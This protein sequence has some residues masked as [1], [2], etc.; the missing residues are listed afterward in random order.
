MKTG[1]TDGG[2]NYIDLPLSK[3]IS[4]YIDYSI[5]RGIF[6]LIPTIIL[7]LDNKIECQQKLNETIDITFSIFCIGISLRIK[8]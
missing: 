4:L 8:K 1:K 6:V 7:F 2:V 5:K 3:T